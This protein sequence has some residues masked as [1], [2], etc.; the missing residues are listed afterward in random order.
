MFCR[1]VFSNKSKGFVKEK[2]N[3]NNFFKNGVF[4]FHNCHHVDMIENVP[5]RT[6]RNK[7]E[8][9]ESNFKFPFLKVGL[10]IVGSQ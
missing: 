1:I 10:D 4:S 7:Q 3:C 6:W 5:R 8:V 2:K 9:R